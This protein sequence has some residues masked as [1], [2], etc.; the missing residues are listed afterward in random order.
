MAKNEAVCTKDMDNKT[1]TVVRSFDAPLDTVWQ[2]WTDSAILDEWWAP[3]P[4]KANTSK[5]DFAEG[6][7]WLYSM[8]GPEGVSAMCRVD[9]TAIQPERS[10][11]STVMF[12]DE[13]GN[14]NTEFPRMYWK[15]VFEDQGEST[16]VT[17]EISFDKTADMEMIMSLGMEEG[18][19]SALGNLDEYLETN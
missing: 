14:E 15:Q 3:R 8:V 9:Y 1:L 12:C 11:T 13:A 10:V 16:K 5:M 17:V 4:Y 18:F 7:Q 6:G 19:V 2:A